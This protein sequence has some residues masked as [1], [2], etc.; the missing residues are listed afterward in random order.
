MA[1]VDFMALLEGL[2]ITH[3][4]SGCRP[5]GSKVFSLLASFLLSRLGSS[6]CA[7]IL[8]SVMQISN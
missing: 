4:A 6:G 5:F 3:I 8:N 7:H 1:L 2:K